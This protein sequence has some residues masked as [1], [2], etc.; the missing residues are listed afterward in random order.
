MVKAAPRS[1]DRAEV[2]TDA[3]T[4]RHRRRRAERNQ[5]RAFWGRR[6]PVGDAHATSALDSFVRVFHRPE[7]V[8]PRLAYPLPPEYVELEEHDTPG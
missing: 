1:V 5:A 8:D 6:A 4:Q 7:R 2:S 3:R